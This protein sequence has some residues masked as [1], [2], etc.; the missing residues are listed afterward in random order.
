MQ[1]NIASHMNEGKVGLVQVNG[2][3]FRACWVE[4]GTRGEFILHNSSYYNM[5]YQVCEPLNANT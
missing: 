1:A 4:L 3:I 5:V 2:G